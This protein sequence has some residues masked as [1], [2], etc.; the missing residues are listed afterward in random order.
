[1]GR[2][3][4]QARR[5]QQV[6]RGQ[7][8]LTGRRALPG[9]TVLRARSDLPGRRARKAIPVQQGLTVGRVLRVLL[10]QQDQRAQ[11][12][13]RVYREIPVPTVHRVPRVRKAPQVPKGLPA[14]RV[15]RETLVQQGQL[16]QMGR[17]VHRA[18]PVPMGLSGLPALPVLQDR[19]VLTEPT[20]PRAHP[21][22]PPSSGL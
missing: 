4:L 8:V 21:V 3:V 1:M 2:K 19:P 16:E 10:V 5:G 17:R 14:R 15:L 6:H 18:I 22:C 13:H 11:M 7:P 9:L 20:G 12:V